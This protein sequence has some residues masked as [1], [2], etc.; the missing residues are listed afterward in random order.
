MFLLG[1]TSVSSHLMQFFK[2]LLTEM[3]YYS[4]YVLLVSTWACVKE[5]KEAVL[6]NLY[7]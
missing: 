7:H 2:R 3:K 4:E 1:Q 6:L 5:H